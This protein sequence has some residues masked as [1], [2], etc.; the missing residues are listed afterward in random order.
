MTNFSCADFHQKIKYIL[1]PHNGIIQW[2]NNLKK[3]FYKHL[4]HSVEKNL[5]NFT[6]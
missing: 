6:G 1:N 5:S 2:N 4:L 3:R